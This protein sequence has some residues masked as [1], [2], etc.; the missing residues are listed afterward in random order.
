MATKKFRYDHPA[1]LQRFLQ[2]AAL[3]GSGGAHRFVAFTDMLV[4][5]YQLK[6]TT[7][8]T[9][10]DTVTAFKLSGTTT[11]TH[12]LCTYGS[13]AGTSTEVLGTFTLAKGD[14]LSIVKG[15][16]A[17]GIIAAGIELSIAARAP[18]TA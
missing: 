2:G 15:T 14:A 9:S 1:Y 18:V 12:A 5:S 17:T 6:P 13:A 3:S 11:S 10:N 7:N 8:G 4:K 16:D